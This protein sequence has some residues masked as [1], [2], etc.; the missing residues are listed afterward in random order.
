MN[1]VLYFQPGITYS[2]TGIN[3]AEEFFQIAQNV[4]NIYL[5]KSLK[6]DTMKQTQY[7]VSYSIIYLACLFCFCFCFAFFV[8]VFLSIQENRENCL[9]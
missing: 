2:M 7:Y 3:R 8:F 9:N 1:C 6:D 4:G 5:K